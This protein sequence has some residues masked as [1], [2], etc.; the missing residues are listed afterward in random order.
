MHI[1]RSSLYVK[2]CVDVRI[3]SESEQLVLLR[4]GFEDYF[5]KNKKENPKG[6]NEQKSEQKNGE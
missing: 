3:Y 6:R 1:Q 5:P 2:M 4:T